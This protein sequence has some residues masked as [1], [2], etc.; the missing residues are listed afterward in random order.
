MIG[1]TV[2]HYKILEKLGEGGMGVVY[3][4]EDLTLNRLV[5]LK[6][7]P[8]ELSTDDNTKT[9]FIHEAKSASSLD[10]PNICTIHEIDE[11]SDG[12]TFIVMPCYEGETLTEKL[13]KGPLEINEAIDVVLQVASGLA[14]AHK[15]G[16]V[17]R[18][19]KPGNILLTND[20]HVKLVDFGIAKLMGQTT[21]TKTGARVGTAGYMSP[22]QALGE[23]LDASSDVFSLGVVLYEL[24]AGRLP[25]R[26]E[27][28]AALLYAI[29]H[30]NTEPLS[31]FRDDIPEVLHQIVEKA[32]EKN[33]ESRYLH[34]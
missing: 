29:V 25:F 4:A 30:G 7:L 31:V 6:F 10:H 16:I 15:K 27:Q 20:G 8:H 9:R 32:L 2:T 1:K 13:G 26:G 18:D 19:I 24:L 3:K 34:E 28:E 21:V 23:E 22:Q 11:T 5:A 14:S 12:R 17:H 33:V